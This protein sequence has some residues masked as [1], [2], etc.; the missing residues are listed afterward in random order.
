[1]TD[2]LLKQAAQQLRDVTPIW[3]GSGLLPLPALLVAEP[4]PDANLACVYLGLA[5]AWL[6]ARFFDR[7]GA[8]RSRSAWCATLLANSVAVSSNVTLFIVL[9]MLVDA[10]STFPLTT[11][12]ILAAF[13][14]V[15]MIPWLIVR[16][17]HPLAAIVIGAMLMLLAKLAG[18]ALARA[19]YGPRFI[20]DGYVAG[21]WRSAKLMIASFWI[22]AS[23]LSLAFLVAGYLSVDSDNHTKVSSA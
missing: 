14:A 23:A 4:A 1:M 2:P 3:I 9:G 16:V 22:I 11:K 5:C 13:P 19:V 17:R 6:A 7:P 12:A 20:A 18:C 15:G 10:K 21:D 8:T